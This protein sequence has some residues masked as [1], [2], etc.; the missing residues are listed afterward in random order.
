MHDD[1]GRASE[2]AALAAIR[3]EGDDQRETGD[4]ADHETGDGASIGLAAVILSTSDAISTAPFIGFLRERATGAIIDAVR[5]GRRRADVALGRARTVY[6]V[7][8][9]VARLARPAR[10]VRV[11]VFTVSATGVRA[12]RVAQRKERSTGRRY[13]LRFASL[14]KRAVREGGIHD[15][16]QG[17]ESSTHGKVSHV[18]RRGCRSSSGAVCR[19]TSPMVGRRRHTSPVA[20]Q[21]VA[22]ELDR[23]VLGEEEI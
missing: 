4:Q 20:G 23:N 12:A 13:V 14:L 8:R 15:A 19:H 1:D 9:E 7:V 21:R 11:A 3:E 17:E 22:G 10:A 2:A 16:Q 18:V 6:R 5:G